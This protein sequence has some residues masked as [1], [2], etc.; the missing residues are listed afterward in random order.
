MNNVENVIICEIPA[1]KLAT[2]H[3]QLVYSI[4]RPLLSLCLS[5][6]DTTDASI[7]F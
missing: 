6:T 2:Q 7:D 3:P 5:H 1:G 4:Q